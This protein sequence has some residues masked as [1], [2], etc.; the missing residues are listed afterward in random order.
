M[1]A[2]WG[3]TSAERGRY[4]MCPKIGHIWYNVMGGSDRASDRERRAKSKYKKKDNK[5][6]AKL[7]DKVLI[8]DTGGVVGLS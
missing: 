3:Q 8:D 2:T 5:R 7:A 4:Q 6:A 1:G